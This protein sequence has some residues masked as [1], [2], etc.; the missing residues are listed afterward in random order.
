MLQWLH[1]RFAWFGL[2]WSRVVRS[3]FLHIVV[4]KVLHHDPSLS[5]VQRRHTPDTALQSSRSESDIFAEKKDRYLSMAN[6]A[7]SASSLSMVREVEYARLVG[8]FQHSVHA[9]QQLCDGGTDAAVDTL[10][11]EEGCTRALRSYAGMAWE[12]FCALE[13][14]WE[15]LQEMLSKY[16]PEEGLSMSRSRNSSR[17]SMNSG[18]AAD[19]VSAGGSRAAEQS[20]PLRMPT[21]SMDAISDDH[22]DDEVDRTDDEW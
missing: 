18:S 22:E 4:M 9:L 14:K 6:K 10:H 8:D 20:R 17:G 19:D 5:T 7:S 11:L 3:I 21:L 12:E 15:E 1:S 2:H 16:H 13:K